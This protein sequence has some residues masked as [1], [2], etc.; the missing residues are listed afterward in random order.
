MIILIKQYIMMLKHIQ[1]KRQETQQEKHT[2]AVRTNKQA[3]IL[4]ERTGWK[5]D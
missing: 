5:R 3:A 1:D 2:R 4:G